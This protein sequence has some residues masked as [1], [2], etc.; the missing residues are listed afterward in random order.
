MLKTEKK[1][2]IK[3]GRKS[4]VQTIENQKGIEEKGEFEYKKL[5]GEFKNFGLVDRN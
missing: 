4:K 1:I 3:N 5:R 2:I